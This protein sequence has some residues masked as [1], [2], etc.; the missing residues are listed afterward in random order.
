[1]GSELFVAL[2]FVSLLHFIKRFAN[3]R[4]EYDIFRLDNDGRVIWLEP[5][6]TLSDAQTRVQQLGAPGPGNYIIFNQK[7]TDKIVLRAGVRP[8]ASD[9]YC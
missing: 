3:E 9:A 6:M 5:V 1:M 4:P 7:T 8:E 2:G